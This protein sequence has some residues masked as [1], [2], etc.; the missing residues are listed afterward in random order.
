MTLSGRI[1]GAFGPAVAV[2]RGSPLAGQEPRVQK[3]PDSRGPPP[4]ASGVPATAGTHLSCLSPGPSHRAR[5]HPTLTRGDP[6]PAPAPRSRDRGAWGPTHVGGAGAPSP[7]I[8]NSR[9]AST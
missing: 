5:T 1:G 2:P 9:P 7:L 3:A 8:I 4:R 6:C